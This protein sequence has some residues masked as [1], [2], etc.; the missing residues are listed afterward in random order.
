MQ[1]NQR[2]VPTAATGATPNASTRIGVISEPPPTPVIPTNAPTPKP[3]TVFIQSIPPPRR[4]ASA[5]RDSSTEQP[6]FAQPLDHLIGRLLGAAVHRVDTQLRFL[7]C[8]VR[9][10]DAS[11]VG[12]LAAARLPVQALHVALL[13]HLERR[14][15]V[16]LDELA[17]AQQA[18][19]HRAF[20]AER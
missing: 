2:S 13:G 14:V 12:E 11:E 5:D 7:R 19:R 18:A 4:S 6:K 16:D 15:D 10:I 20:R 8:L 17:F 9:R 3:A 1:A